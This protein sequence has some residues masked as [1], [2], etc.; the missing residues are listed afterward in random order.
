MNE[1]DILDSRKFIGKLL[2]KHGIHIDEKDPAFCVVLL[3][4]Y[5]LED[6]VK[7]IVEKIQRAGSEFEGAAERV[8]Q[9]A[10]QFFAEQV[11]SPAIVAG[12][13]AREWIAVGIA[14]ALVIFGAGIMIGIAMKW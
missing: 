6:A 4:K 14:S 13:T 8:Q 2:E 5:T 11:K 9:R 7:N 10:G 3:N 1:Q 12:T